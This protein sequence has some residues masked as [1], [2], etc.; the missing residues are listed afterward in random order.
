MICKL[1]NNPL[2]PREVVA[3]LRQNGW[4]GVLSDWDAELSHFNN[5]EDQEALIQNSTAIKRTY[6]DLRQIPWIGEWIEKNTPKNADAEFQDAWK[7]TFRDLMIRKDRSEKAAEANLPS[8]ESA[9]KKAEKDLNDEKDPDVKEKTL[10]PFKDK[11]ALYRNPLFQIEHTRL[12][13]ALLNLEEGSQVYGGMNPDA[14]AYREWL[15]KYKTWTESGIPS[16]RELFVLLYKACTDEKLREQLAVERG[17]HLIVEFYAS[18]PKGMNRSRFSV[19]KNYLDANPKDHTYTFKDCVNMTQA[20]AQ[21]P[22]LLDDILEGRGLF[23]FQKS[24]QAPPLKQRNSIASLEMMN[25]NYAVDFSNWLS[26]MMGLQDRYKEFLENAKTPDLMPMIEAVFAI[27]RGHNKKGYFTL[28]PSDQPS[29]PQG[30][31]FNLLQKLGEI[32]GIGMNHQLL[33]CGQ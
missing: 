15:E 4:N 31:P 29:C 21:N 24:L 7:E 10:K 17:K 8:A 30:V 22:G 18:H 23:D 13:L 33:Q 27:Q 16:I 1:R 9:L 19:L 6:L 14:K 26:G 2:L 25:Q 28:D 12:G 11:V 32:F 3:D 20:M 5:P